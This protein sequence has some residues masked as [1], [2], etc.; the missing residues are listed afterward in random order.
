MG[1]QPP[2]SGLGSAKEKKAEASLRLKKPIKK[3]ADSTPSAAE[4]LQ[5]KKEQEA[6]RTEHLAA[7]ARLR[8]EYERQQRKPT[9]GL[10]RP[11]RMT[12]EE[13]V[14]MVDREIL[15]IDS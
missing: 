11:S 12:P 8:A 2:G 15:G 4:A 10:L 7:Q 3:S 6:I 13:I 14:R 9:P 1:Y 5:R